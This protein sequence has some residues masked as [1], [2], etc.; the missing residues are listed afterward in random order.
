[1]TKLPDRMEPPRTSVLFGIQRSPAQNACSVRYGP[2]RETRRRHLDEVRRKTGCGS[3]PADSRAP[4]SVVTLVRRLRKSCSRVPAESM[5]DAGS[6]PGWCDCTRQAR[7]DAAR[8]GL[9]LVNF[10]QWKRCRTTT[11][12]GFATSNASRPH[13]GMA[14]FLQRGNPGSIHSAMISDGMRRR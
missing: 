9:T 3:A 1:M 12:L 6:A 13:C 11:K 10:R 14:R 7:L 4:F 8:I 5:A 2:V